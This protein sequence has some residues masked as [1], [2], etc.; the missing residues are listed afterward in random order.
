VPIKQKTYAQIPC[1]T[2]LGV[3]LRDVCTYAM[4]TET[5]PDQLRYRSNLSAWEPGAS[6]LRLMLAGGAGQAWLPGHTNAIFV[7]RQR[8]WIYYPQPF[9]WELHRHAKHSQR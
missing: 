1:R 9:A 7:D 6:A 3:S 2:L 5:V 8:P 4:C